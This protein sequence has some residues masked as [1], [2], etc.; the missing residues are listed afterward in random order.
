[1]KPTTEPGLVDNVN[2]MTTA[3]FSERVSQLSLVH[4]FAWFL[5]FA[6]VTMTT[7][8]LLNW[9]LRG[10]Q[11]TTED[12]DD[13]DEEMSNKAA[14]PA[15]DSSQG[16]HSGPLGSSLSSSSR[17]VTSRGNLARQQFLESRKTSSAA[18]NYGSTGSTSSAK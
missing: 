9:C 6:T 2:K 11:V 4:L 1:M 16:T 17:L 15:T 5:L 7:V 10:L 14:V 18:K 3:S 12:I 13:D 8:V